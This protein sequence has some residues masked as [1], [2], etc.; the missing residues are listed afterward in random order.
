MEI[1]D[2]LTD[3]AVTLDKKTNYMTYLKE[4]R[5]TFADWFENPI[6]SEDVVVEEVDTVKYK[7]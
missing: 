6:P 7:R 5:T 1:K 3:P 4:G 2:L